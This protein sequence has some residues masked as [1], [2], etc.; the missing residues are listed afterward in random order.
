MCLKEKENERSCSKN[1][2]LKVQLNEKERQKN[3]DG[4]RTTT[5]E[6]KETEG[7]M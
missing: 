6:E 4:E 1:S 3:V 7:K 5:K 2:I